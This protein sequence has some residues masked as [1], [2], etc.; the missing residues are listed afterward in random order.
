MGRHSP[1]R[2]SELSVLRSRSRREEATVADHETP[3]PETQIYLQR[4]PY[5]RK[6]GTGS[7]D[8]PEPR[9]WR[10]R[11]PT[12]LL[13]SWSTCDYADFITAGTVIT[14]ACGLDIGIIRRSA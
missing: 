8:A 6:T 1:V 14:S 5:P 7:N 10:Y 9:V 13:A 2:V 4:R 11:A 12:P 3:R